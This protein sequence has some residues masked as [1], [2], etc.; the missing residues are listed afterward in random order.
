MDVG[1]DYG[2]PDNGACDDGGHNAV[3]EDHT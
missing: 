2:N 3:C 1:N